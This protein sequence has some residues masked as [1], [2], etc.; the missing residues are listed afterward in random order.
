MA[1]LLARDSSSGRLPG[2]LTSGIMPI[3]LA[4]SGGSAGEWLIS[5]GT[6]LPYQ[7]R[8]GTVIRYSVVIEPA[9]VTVLKY[10]A[11]CVLSRTDSD[12]EWS[13]SACFSGV[14]G[15]MHSP[16]EYEADQE[17]QSQSQSAANSRRW[18]RLKLPTLRR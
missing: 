9:I 5:S 1:G 7:A 13:L 12:G 17:R 6:P 18:W 8:A 4:Y 16:F 14:S 15:R 3:V 11:P 10:H 2:Q